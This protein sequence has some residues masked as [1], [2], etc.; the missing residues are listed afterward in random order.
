MILEM[1][2]PP[3]S[4]QAIFAACAKQV[5]ALKEMDAQPCLTCL[6]AI[7]LVAR[8]LGG[9]C[10]RQQLRRPAAPAAAAAAGNRVGRVGPGGWLQ[11]QRL[12]EQVG[13]RR[14]GRRLQHGRHQHLARHTV[15]PSV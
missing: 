8:W 3:G 14:V 4:T 2:T 6:H 1:V 7:S 12:Q 11:G 9:R 5:G 15:Q 10:L 13:Q